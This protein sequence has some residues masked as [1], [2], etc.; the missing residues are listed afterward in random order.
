MKSV[1]AMSSSYSQL[2]EVARRISRDAVV[3]SEAKV[4]NARELW[5][6]EELRSLGK[7]ARP[8]KRMD[9]E[10]PVPCVIAA[11]LPELDMGFQ[12]SG[13]GLKR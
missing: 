9:A 5:P 12:P 7:I 11:E 13:S 3:A 1:N 2:P 6:P 4:V 8:R 10:P